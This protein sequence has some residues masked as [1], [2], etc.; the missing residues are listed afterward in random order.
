[1]KSLCFQFYIAITAISFC[2]SCSTEQI[3]L[4]D[5]ISKVLP[6]SGIPFPDAVDGILYF[7]DIDH[8]N[9][10]YSAIDSVAN[11]TEDRDSMLAI[12]EAELDYTS[13]RSILY[14]DEVDDTDELRGLLDNDFVRDGI[15]KSILNEYYEFGIGD[16]VYVYLSPNQTYKIE[17]GDADMIALFRNTEKNQ[18][19]IPMKLLNPKTLLMPSAL[20]GGTQVL[21]RTPPSGNFVYRPSYSATLI[22]CNSLSRQISISFEESSNNV[23]WTSIEM[24]SIEIDFGDGSDPLKLENVVYVSIP[25]TWPDEGSYSITVKIEYYNLN[26]AALLEE[27]VG[28]GVNLSQNCRMEERITD[29][30]EIAS[31][32]VWMI[33]AELWFKSP[34]FAFTTKAGA[35][36]YGW[37][38]EGGKWR[39]KKSELNVAIDAIFRGGQCNIDDTDDESDHCNKC[40][41]QRAVVS[42]GG[43]F[44]PDLYHVDGEISSTHRLRHTDPSTDIDL[45]LELDCN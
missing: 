10:Y 3:K 35:I 42:A 37:R 19:T 41:S 38:F 7:E 2:I 5:N 11:S 30:Y 15:R 43:F 22:G 8:L 17:D 40:K 45:E 44:S 32:N 21:P 29:D 28:F 18:D 4:D 36:T 27:Q 9:D 25:H 24:E 23:D 13:L 16:D 12:I 34:D 1:M 31:N 20:V 26:V 6:R 33:T 14:F 39:R